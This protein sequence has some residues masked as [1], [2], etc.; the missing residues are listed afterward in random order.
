MLENKSYM[1]LFDRTSDPINTGSETEQKNLTTSY[2]III[3]AKEAYRLLICNYSISL[4]S[5]LLHYT[6]RKLPRF[7]SGDYYR[8]N[9]AW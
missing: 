2:E 6:T 9:G 4:I 7:S 8:E 5:S 3:I 1:Y